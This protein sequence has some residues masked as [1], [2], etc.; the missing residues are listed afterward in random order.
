ML[1]GNSLF[2]F[3]LFKFCQRKYDLL[4]LFQK[5]FKKNITIEPVEDPKGSIERVLKTKYAGLK[6][7]F[8]EGNTMSVVVQ[9]LKDFLISANS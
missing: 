9:E 1:A 2:R 8:Q 4:S 5:V 3:L 7:L 6:R